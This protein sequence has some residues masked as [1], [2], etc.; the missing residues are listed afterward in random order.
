L[1]A[2]PCEPLRLARN[3]ADGGDDLEIAGAATEIARDGAPDLGIS[4][5]GMLGEKGDPRQQKTRGAIAALNSAV[6]NKGPLEWMQ[7]AIM[8]QAFNRHDAATV[9][10]ECGIEARVDRPP[11]DEY[12]ASATLAFLATDLGSGKVQLLAQ[13]RCQCRAGSHLD[14]NLLAIQVH[15]QGVGS[16]HLPYPRAVVMARS[17]ARLVRTPINSRRYSLPARSRL[18][19]GLLSCTAASTASLITSSVMAW[20]LSVLS[21]S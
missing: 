14:L 2:R 6:L 5:V 19:R 13:H 12:G 8:G 20:P 17:R 16:G 4:G 1:D 7:L 15:V 11:I 10:F 18:V 3:L 21:A 9:G